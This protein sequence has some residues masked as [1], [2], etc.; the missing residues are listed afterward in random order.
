MNRR[1]ASLAL[2]ALATA[3]FSG[4]CSA[5][6]ASAPTAVTPPW[7]LK[8]VRIINPFPVGG[9]P[10]GTA[11]IVADKLSR[12]WQQPVVVDNRPGGNGY[13]AIAAFKRGATDGSDILLLDNVHIAAYP[14][15]F[16]KL[17]YNV[18]RDFRLVLPLFR[19]FFFVCVPINSP[20]QS[21]A[22]LIA[23]AKA[24][25]GALNYGSWSLGNA[26]HL[27]SA[28]LESLT[29]TRMQHVIYKETSQLYANVA[30]GVLA[31]A[32]GT[33]ATAGPLVQAGKLRFLAVMAP[34]RLRGYE[35]VPTV[36]QS[37]GPAQ[38]IA[39]GWNAL[40]VPPSAPLEAI[41]A[42]RRDVT[43][44]LKES[45]IS[46]KFQTF[47]YE[48]YFPTPQEFQQFIQQEQARFSAVIRRANLSL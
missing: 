47:G 4:I 23:D 32:L 8:P 10:D 44:A 48:N 14:Y 42:I 39:T 13:I 12:K 45:D 3:P 30:S 31:F 7:P 5:A 18:D 27:G 1:T 38:A 25:P 21:M 26:V 43:Q 6:P 29:N 37:G 35:H 34:Q 9:G 33:S 46:A 41:E 24:R 15:L 40:A 19:T 16:K 36:A 22:E 17:P 11:R 28:L 20:Y 2:G